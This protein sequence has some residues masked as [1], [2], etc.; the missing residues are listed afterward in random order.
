MDAMPIQLTDLDRRIWDEELAG[1]VPDRIFDAHVHCMHEDFSS[2][3]HK[4]RSI[5]GRLEEVD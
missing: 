2:A 3:L 1:F 4:T 5:N